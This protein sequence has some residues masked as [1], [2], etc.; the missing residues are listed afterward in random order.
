MSQQ[1]I[2][3]IPAGVGPG[4]T[5]QVATP[6]GVMSV[7]CPSNL[8]AGM[9]MQIMVTQPMAQAV[10]APQVFVQPAPVV[11]PPRPAYTGYNTAAQDTAMMMGMVEGAIIAEEC[12]HHHRHHHHHHN[13]FREEII[14]GPGF[15]EEII[16]ERGMFGGGFR[17]EII[18]GPGF[19][20]EIIETRGPFG[21][22]R[23][24][25]IIENNARW[26]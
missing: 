24:E 20:E 19:R 4:G 12:R 22:V 13:G 14:Q 18:Q 6:S 26:W 25:V 8:Q 11:V 23:E 15:R 9:Q 7:Q 10:A 16:E 3:T 17:E 1:M 5:F 21:G 2:V